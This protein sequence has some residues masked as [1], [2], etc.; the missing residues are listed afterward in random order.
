MPEVTFEMI[1]SKPLLVNDYK[2]LPNNTFVKTVSFGD[3]YVFNTQ[4][5]L[6]AFNKTT[7][8]HTI[9]G[10][11]GRGSNEF[12]LIWD[13]VENEDFLNVYD[14]NLQKVTTYDLN[15]NSVDEKIVGVTGF[16]VF[17]LTDNFVLHDYKT[18]KNLLGITNLETQETNSFH[19]LLIPIGY[20]PQSYNFAEAN[21]YQNSIYTKYRNVDSL[22]IYNILTQNLVDVIPIY[23]NY[24]EEID[25]PPLT[26]FKGVYTDGILNYFEGFNIYDENT[27]VALIERQLTLLK[28][29]STGFHAVYSIVLVDDEDNKKYI[30]NFTVDD[31]DMI[32]IVG[33]LDYTLKIPLS[34]LLEY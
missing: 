5:E 19:K 27:I 15:L 9:I 3:Y 7:N 28:K 10:S 12:L 8:A 33:N 25:N 11:K 22:Y 1:N 6:H 26:P 20:E 14:I 32:V 34:E 2:H 29:N 17:D 18:D 31:T 30:S 24:S 16:F 4:T 23:I 21:F 13:L